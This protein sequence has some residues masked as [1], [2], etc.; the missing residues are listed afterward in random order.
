MTSRTEH[1]AF[2]VNVL[3]V[4]AAV[5]DQMQAENAARIAGRAAALDGQSRGMNPYLPTDEVGE[6]CA[7]LHEFERAER[8]LEAFL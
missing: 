5:Y 4:P 8:G 7:W 3:G 6:H 1:R 2:A